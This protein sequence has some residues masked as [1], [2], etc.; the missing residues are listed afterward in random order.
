MSRMPLAKKLLLVVLDGWG[1][2]EV[3]EYNAIAMANKPNFDRL[4]SEFPNR[5]IE[6]SQE[7]VGLPEGQMGNSEVGHLTLGAGRIIYQP[8]VRINRAISDGSLF[9]NEEVLAGF[10]NAK[11]KGGSLHLL[12]LFSG[13][14]VHSHMD[15]MYALIRMALDNKLKRIRL[16]LVTDGRDVSPHSAV[17]DIAAL[18]EWIAKNDPR[19]CVR[20]ATVM[21]RFYSMDRDR[22]WD[23]TEEAL[24]YYTVPMEGISSDP[25]AAIKASY[26]AGVTDEFI[27]PFQVAGP[28]GSPNGLVAD[29]DTIIFFNFRPDRA[30]QITKAFIYPYFGGF[31]RPK[32]VRPYFVAMTDYDETIYT[33]VGFKEAPINNCVGEVISRA[34][35]RQ[36]RIAETEKY[37]HV[38]FFFS[39]GREEPYPNEARVL[40]PSPNV[41][42]YDLAPEMSAPKLTES[43]V[44]ELEAG[45]FGFGI[46]NFANSDMVGHTGV[47]DAAISAVEAVDRCIGKVF[48]AGMDSDYHVIFTA[49]HGNSEKMW[50]FENDLPFTAHT[51]NPVPFIYTGQGVGKKHRLSDA[52]ANLSDV[53]PTILHQMGITLP[54]Q[55]TGKVLIEQ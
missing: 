30:R 29:D 18:Q 20:I 25:V 23:R 3:R 12:G 39:G 21:G 36:L 45:T 17:Q 42:T 4:V 43:I 41:R 34:G 49:D 15:H 24:N 35:L 16:H 10:E 33:H 1:H 53:G 32:V 9:R 7:H 19:G 54:D 48:K 28:D 2:S 47:L 14:G 31:I 55:M 38:T 6:A 52:V 11:R 5:F 50:D 51:I 37:A 44:K 26:D 27:R 40:I 8:L 46:L 13:G 22:R